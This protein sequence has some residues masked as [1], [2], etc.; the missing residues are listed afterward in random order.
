[1]PSSPASP[2]PPEAREVPVVPDAIDPIVSPVHHLKL[3]SRRF[4]SSLLGQLC[5]AT[6]GC[7]LLGFTAATAATLMLNYRM[8]IREHEQKV[9]EN[10]DD[11]IRILEARPR[12]EPGQ[13]QKQLRNQ[14]DQYASEDGLYWIEWPDGELTLPTAT[15]DIHPEDM[16]AISQNRK[17]ASPGFLQIGPW[18]QIPRLPAA[19]TDSKIA[20]S[21]P[22]NYSFLPIQKRVYLVHPHYRTTNQAVIWAGKDISSEI[23]LLHNEL[24]TKLLVWTL[25]SALTLLAISLLARRIF[26]PLNDLILTAKNFTTE[27]LET[28]AFT[29]LDPSPQLRRA[30]R[31]VQELAESYSNLVSRVALAWSHQREFV[32]AVS[33][34]LRNPLTIIGGHLRRVQRRGQNLDPEQIRALATAEAEAHRITRLL[35]DL[36]D[37]SRSEAGR[38]ELVIKPVAVDEVLLQSCDLARSQLARSLNLKLPPEAAEGPIMAVAESDRL[39][40]VVL[41]LIENADKYSP[42]GS[43]ITVEL[44][45]EGDQEVRISIHDEGIGIEDADL[46]LIFNRFHR[47]RNALNHARGSGLG[48]SIVKLLVDGMGARISVESH[49]ERGSS[50]HLHLPLTAPPAESPA[51][52]NAPEPAAA[53]Q[54]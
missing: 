7:V 21:L 12:S 37:L 25:F 17:I 53:S 39:Q 31:E 11:L 45:Q 9:S 32:N 42:P 46:P 28:H 10:A 19:K 38:L 40:Q 30:P 41:N 26:Q 49:L 48:L 18:R 50:F 33:H 14:L 52:S 15:T 27:N 34:E 36:L 23:A 6:L 13:W 29:P 20:Q 54:T 22:S 43:P 3:P 24:L 8:L 51:V 4:T 1:M 35:N 2:W 44:H 16:R 47:G 5:L